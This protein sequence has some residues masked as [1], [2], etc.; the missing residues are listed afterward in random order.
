MK[1]RLWLDRSPRGGTASV[2][3]AWAIAR[4]FCHGAS[5]FVTRMFCDALIRIRNSQVQ[6]ECDRQAA[7]K[8]LNVRSEKPACAA[9]QSVKALGPAEI[10]GFGARPELKILA[11]QHERDTSFHMLNSKV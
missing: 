9:H 7:V 5:S 6:L 3:A 8:P 4:P 1:T 2:G 11:G 10:T